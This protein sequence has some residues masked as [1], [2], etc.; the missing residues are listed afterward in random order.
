MR[1][2][3][4]KFFDNQTEGPVLM[5]RDDQPIDK[6][7]SEPPE[8]EKCKSLD[9]M[10]EAFA[11]T[12]KDKRRPTGVDTG[13]VG[14][15]RPENGMNVNDDFPGFKTGKK[16][17]RHTVLRNFIAEST[18]EVRMEDR[19]INMFPGE[20]PKPPGRHVGI[21]DQLEEE[22]KDKIR[23]PPGEAGVGLTTESDLTLR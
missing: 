14:S 8:G 1:S 11:S 18:G 5:V 9:D 3:L 13:E 4:D 21:M 19:S 10:I 22:L 20:E 6:A 16:Q 12:E 15:E 2:I 17:V 7:N 23:D